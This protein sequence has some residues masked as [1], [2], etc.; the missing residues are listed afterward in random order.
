MKKTDIIMPE[1]SIIKAHKRRKRL[2]TVWVNGG[3]GNMATLHVPNTIKDK[4]HKIAVVLDNETD[5]KVQLKKIKEILKE[6]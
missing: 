5:L 2:P 3:R 1:Y 6:D 4:A